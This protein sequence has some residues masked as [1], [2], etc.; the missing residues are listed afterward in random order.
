M[1]SKLTNVCY[2]TGT[3]TNIGY[4]YILQYRYKYK[5][6]LQ[7]YVTFRRKQSCSKISKIKVGKKPKPK[8]K[9]NIKRNKRHLEENKSIYHILLPKT[10][11]RFPC[12]RLIYSSPFYQ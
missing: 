1:G 9:T 5:Y 6:R 11:V 12:Y 10:I 4:K 7:I 2:N 8:P 3:D